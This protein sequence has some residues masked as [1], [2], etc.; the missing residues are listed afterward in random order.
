LVY[1]ILKILILVRNFISFI[2][3]LFFGGRKERESLNSGVER[4]RKKIAVG[5]DSNHQTQSIICV[6]WFHV[7]RRV[8]ISFSFL[9]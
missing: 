8:Q 3:Q 9:P 5:D 2:F 7:M 1:A 4:E 6:K